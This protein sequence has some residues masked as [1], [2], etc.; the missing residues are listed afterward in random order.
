MRFQ[1]NHA[2]KG[3]SLVEI[4][5]SLVLGLFLMGGIFQ[6]Y[7][8]NKQAYRLNDALARLQENGRFAMQF[9]ARD[10]RL[11]G[12]TGCGGRM[13][14][15]ANTLNATA[16]PRFD[17][18]KYVEGHESTGSGWSPAIDAQVIDS[19]RSGSDILVVRGAFSDPV[20]IIG[21]PNNSADCAAGNASSHTADLKVNTTAGLVAGDVV[22]ATDCSHATIFQITN[23]NQGSNIVHNTG[24]V[25]APGNRTKD[26]QACYAGNGHLM[27]METRIYYIRDNDRGEPALYRIRGTAAPEELVEGVEQLQVLYGVDTDHDR[28]AN[29]YA[30]A[31]QITANGEWE[32]VVSLR[33]GLLLH[34]VQDQITTAP[35]PYT[36]DG[37]TTTPD[38]R[39]L[40][41]VFTT[42]VALRNLT[43]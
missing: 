12:F 17:F 1:P 31:D 21:Q 20:Q 32:R 26:L 18:A 4:L 22:L 2:P 5:I 15:V 10:L 14:E 34:S 40:R 43:P 16:D 33:L 13:R 19:P 28:S 42:T 36:F 27:K 29:K 35:Q 25:V 6:V 11:G 24:N 8:S 3:F 30:T 39:R 38:D 9:L 37:T 41:R 23:I 7:L